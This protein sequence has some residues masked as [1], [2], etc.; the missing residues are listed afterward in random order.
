MGKYRLTDKRVENLKPRPARYAV[1]DGGGLGIRV[2]PS[3]QRTWF[4]V[5]RDAAGKQH[6]LTL[7]EYPALSLAKAR[8]AHTERLEALALGKSIGP[9]PGQSATFT[10]ADLWAEFLESHV[11][12]RLRERTQGQYSDSWRNHLSPALGTRRLSGITKADVR[13][14]HAMIGGSGKHG[15]ANLAGAVL[16][17]M[18]GFAIEQEM[19]PEPNPAAGVKFYATRK[20]A[21]VLSTDEIARLYHALDEDVQVTGDWT[22]HDIVKLA[23]LSGQRRAH[24]L[25][26]RWRDFDLPARQWRIPA[27]ETKSR[28]LY[29]VHLAPGAVDL[30]NRRRQ[31][32]PEDAELVFP[33][34]PGMTI[35]SYLRQRW[36]L[37]RENAGL[38]DFRFHDLRHS[39]A[40]LMANAGASLPIIA[41]QLQHASIATTQRYAHLVDATVALAVD[42][43]TAALGAN[44]SA[45]QLADK[46]R[47]E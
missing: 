33:D 36:D 30:L 17:S 24:V 31:A 13:T 3:G 38:E 4:M 7:G 37:I 1:H 20:R 16:R 22:A 10:L 29:A 14:L 11:E 39:T 47:E 15:A 23:L 21:R 28:R 5:Y 27:A 2:G 35:L 25:G 26:A 6:R 43:A 18:F 12:Q 19:I 8:R 45:A 32:A 34:P 44:G 42:N 46:E 9:R 41:R 40:S